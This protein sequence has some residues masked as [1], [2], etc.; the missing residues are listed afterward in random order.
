M[1]TKETRVSIPVGFVVVTA[2]AS[3][4]VGA[5]AIGLFA[6]DLVPSLSPPAVAWSLLGV[7]IVLDIGAVMQ[8]LSARKQGS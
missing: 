6:P 7:G 5:G 3:L 4:F 2:L 1:N 8:L